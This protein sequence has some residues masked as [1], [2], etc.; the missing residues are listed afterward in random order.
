M[1]IR[2]QEKMCKTKR[3]K[4]RSNKEV[5]TTSEINA[6]VCRERGETKRESEKKGRKHRIDAALSLRFHYSNFSVTLQPVS[7]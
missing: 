6:T 5:G 3:A 1:R 7:C 2:K 4:N